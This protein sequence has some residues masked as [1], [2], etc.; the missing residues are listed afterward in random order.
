M[1]KIVEHTYT[2]NSTSFSPLTQ[3]S[4]MDSSAAK[5]KEVIDP[6][7]REVKVG[8]RRGGR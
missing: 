6:G 2:H 7:I 1:R 4:K 5:Y 8:K 3:Y